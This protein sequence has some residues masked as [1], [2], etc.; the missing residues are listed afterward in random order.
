MRLA[1]DEDLESWK[2]WEVISE[3]RTKLDDE[4]HDHAG[5]IELPVGLSSD[6]DDVI[7]AD[8]LLV[9]MA[10][11]RGRPVVSRAPT[12][13]DTEQSSRG[14]RGGWG[15]R[16]RGRGRGRGNRGR[17]A[18]RGRGGQGSGDNEAVPVGFCPVL[19]PM[20]VATSHQ[21]DRRGHTSQAIS[22]TTGA[23]TGAAI[24]E[25]A[26]PQP[27]VPQPS[28]PSIPEFTAAP[29]AHLPTSLVAQSALSAGAQPRTESSTSLGPAARSSSSSS[30]PNVPTRSVSHSEASPARPESVRPAAP[31][32]AIPASSSHTAASLNTR[33]RPLT[34]NRQ[35]PLQQSTLSKFWASTSERSAATPAAPVPS[36]ELSAC[37]EPG[38]STRPPASVHPSQPPQS[39]LR[40]SLL[41]RAGQA[42]SNDPVPDRT[43][44]VS[45][46]TKA[47]GA[48]ASAFA[49]HTISSD[50]R[51]EQGGH[52]LSRTESSSAHQRPRSAIHPE[53]V[54]PPSPSSSSASMA[55]PVAREQ[56]SG[57]PESSSVHRAPSSVQT[58]LHLSHTE[59]SSVRA[60]PPSVREQP[61]LAHARPQ[62]VPTESSSVRPKP[63]PVHTAPSSVPA[64]SSSVRTQPSALHVQPSLNA[65]KPASKGPEPSTSSIPDS[66]LLRQHGQ[67]PVT[68]GVIISPPY[69]VRGQQSPTVQPPCHPPAHQSKQVTDCPATPRAPPGDDRPLHADQ[70]QS[71]PETAEA[72]LRPLSHFC[73]PALRLA[74][75]EGEAPGKPLGVLGHQL[76]ESRR[77]GRIILAPES[78]DVSSDDEEADVASNAGPP[79]SS[80][81]YAQLRPL[82]MTTVGQRPSRPFSLAMLLG[83]TATNEQTSVAG[84]AKR[85]P[86]SSENPP[87]SPD[88][89]LHVTQTSRPDDI[90]KTPSAFERVVAASIA[91]SAAVPK[92][93][94]FPVVTT[95]PRV[96]TPPSPS[97]PPSVR[98]PITLA[99]MEALYTPRE[100][101]RRL[102]FTGN[103]RLWLE[104]A[105]YRRAPTMSSA[106]HSEG[107]NSVQ[108]ST[109]ATSEVEP[110]ASRQPDGHQDTVDQPPAKANKKRKRASKVVDEA[111]RRRSTRPTPSLYKR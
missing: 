71:I 58:R 35:L 7:C 74:P 46:T 53:D 100:I 22:T 12:T 13:I 67:A 11:K 103:Y 28:A 108:A 15:G 31:A 14:G 34:S 78:S 42:A 16:G 52:D 59:A 47:I 63:S 21:D 79:S 50:A 55:Q 96:A 107:R 38:P 73:P 69:E 72:R 56:L 26:V 29:A 87:S 75:N 64:Q 43:G 51:Q 60:E 54:S 45:A 10:E 62:S 48:A 8:P 19:R 105:K 92:S 81:S 94:S 90:S 70:R 77:T 97:T 83:P 36:V 1:D 68:A 9:L 37:A 104:G 76:Q 80:S 27:I 102:T 84:A 82:L 6:E 99:D 44:S 109:G 110:A 40:T 39:L 86:R 111:N 32:K 20:T 98:R 30:R 93:P 49:S 41:R 57:Y 89:P 65:S 3:R 18:R 101:R 88:P 66:P 4:M 24:P 91:P 95:P 17:G 2:Q 5:A 33:A 23:S 25:P 61:S 85:L 106:D